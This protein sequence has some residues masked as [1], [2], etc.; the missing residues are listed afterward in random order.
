LCKNGEHRSFDGVYYIPR[1]TTN[2]VSVGKL[3]ETGYN[4]HIQGG[5]MCIRESGE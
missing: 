3:D 1:L 2:I 4:I 5:R